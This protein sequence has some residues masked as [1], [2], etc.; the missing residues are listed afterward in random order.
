MS[1]VGKAVKKAARAVEPKRP[2]PKMYGKK[3]K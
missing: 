2:K 1:A 3:K